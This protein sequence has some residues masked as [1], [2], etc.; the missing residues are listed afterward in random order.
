[1]GILLIGAPPSPRAGADGRGTDG[2]GLAVGSGL[3]WSL[4]VEFNI[5]V[6]G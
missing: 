4:S 2:K 5:E 3:Y 1:M 6:E